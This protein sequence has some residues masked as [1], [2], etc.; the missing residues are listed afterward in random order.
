MLFKPYVIPVLSSPGNNN[1][2]IM[3]VDNAGN[4][5]I[6]PPFTIIVTNTNYTTILTILGAIG[7]S[8]M[9]SLYLFWYYYSS[10]KKKKNNKNPAKNDVID[11]IKKVDE[12]SLLDEDKVK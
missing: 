5:Q 7:F 1:L 4:I 8:L 2:T 6:S 11:Y 3:A 12:K 10:K 9:F